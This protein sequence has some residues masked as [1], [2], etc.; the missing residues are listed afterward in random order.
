VD[1]ELKRKLLRLFSMGVFAYLFATVCV[2]MLPVFINTK[3][4]NSILA[5]QFLVHLA[6]MASLVWIFR[7]GG[8]H[9]QGCEGGRGGPGQGARRQAAG[10]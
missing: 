8:R 9:Q 4:Q 6:F 7:W 10:P 3:V 5:G 1:F 2:L